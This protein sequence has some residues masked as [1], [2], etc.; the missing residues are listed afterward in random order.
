MQSTIE[1]ATEEIA[2]PNHEYIILR[3]VVPTATGVGKNDTLIMKANEDGTTFTL[4]NGRTGVRA[5]LNKTRNRILPM[6]TWDD[7]FYTQ[8]RQRFSIYATEELGKKEI[9]KTGDYRVITDED[10]KDIVTILMNAANQVMEEQYSVKVEDIPDNMLQKGQE[11]LT[12][13]AS[14]G[15]SIS[16]AEFNNELLQLWTAIPR[17][18]KNLSKMKVTMKSDYA[19]KLSQEQDLLDFLIAALRKNGTLSS[20]DGTILDANGLKWQKV[21]KEEEKML[22]DKMGADR[23]RYLR[24]WRITNV[25]TE[26]RFNKYV[27]AHEACQKEDGISH[28][29]HGSGTENFWSI[30]CNGLYLNPQGVRIAGKAFGHGL[31]FA[32][33]ARK[34]IGYTSSSGSYWRSGD[35]SRGYLA[36]FKVA[37]GNVFDIYGAG[38]QGYGNCP[39]NY[40]DLQARQADADCLWAYNHNVNANSPLA[41][42][43][44]IVYREDQATIEYLIEFTA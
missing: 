43:E 23:A 4:S 7:F 8:L 2:V 24:A 15:E 32:P 16:V 3:R 37:T 31:Y 5:G 20:A 39:D 12:N 9:K 29:F 1:S 22:K 13:L 33:R 19:E 18:V 17:P 25:E 34:S 36:V 42:D 27:K 35:Q 14:K 44:V 26:N 38:G 6:D 28:L 40:Q 21:S 10:V 11:I 30:L 41:N